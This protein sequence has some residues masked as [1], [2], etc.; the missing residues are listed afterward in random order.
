MII[1]SK[2]MWIVASFEYKR[3][4]EVKMKSST[5][6]TVGLS[7]AAVAGIATTVIVTE[8]VIRKALEMSNRRKVKNFIKVK[9]K[10]NDKLLDI[11]DNLDDK[12][13]ATLVTAGKK[14]SQGFERV[15]AYGENVADATHETKEKVTNFVESLF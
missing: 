10:G 12:D 4:A 3:G 8:K 9:L 6:V 11:V 14:M 7:I 13:I 1:M 5:K 15:S 2:M